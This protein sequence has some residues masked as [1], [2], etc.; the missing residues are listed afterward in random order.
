MI[1]RIIKLMLTLAVAVCLIGLLLTYLLSSSKCSDWLCLWMQA[2]GVNLSQTLVFLLVASTAT[3]MIIALLM[4][5][6][7][8][9]G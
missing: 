2:H 9:Q 3:M 8:G 4:S 1:E 5:R 7:K 6:G